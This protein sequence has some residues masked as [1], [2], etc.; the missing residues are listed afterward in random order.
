MDAV[1]TVVSE[2][3]VVVA[4]VEVVT[5]DVVVAVADVVV[6]MVAGVV[7]VVVVEAVVVAMVVIV[8]VVKAVV[9]VVVV[10]VRVVS[11]TAAIVVAVVAMVSV[12]KRSVMASV[13]VAAP[14]VV[15]WVSV[16]KS[17]VVTDGVTET[18]VTSNAKLLADQSVPIL[19]SGVVDAGCNM[20]VLRSEL[21]AVSIV[22]LHWFTEVVA[23]AWSFV[24]AS[25]A[26]VP[27][28]A[29]V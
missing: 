27:E 6:K 14:S 2:V 15:L 4:P 26:V 5:V 21:V 13:A 18:D 29:F 28:D 10:I 16:F 9:E 8:V 7:V 11:V 25:L 23:R 20:V 17:L 19:E 22:I 24:V 3:A 12:V 1:V